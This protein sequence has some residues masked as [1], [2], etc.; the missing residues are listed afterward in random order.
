MACGSYGGWSAIVG[1]GGYG[2]AGAVPT[3]G[4]V[5]SRTYVTPQL[6]ALSDWLARVN[7]PGDNTH[8]LNTMSLGTNAYIGGNELD[9]GS[10][11]AP[12][13]PVTGGG[14]F[15]LQGGT[16]NFDIPG[17]TTGGGSL[18]AA[19]GVLNMQAGP[20][21]LQGGV[22]TNNATATPDGSSIILNGNMKYNT[23][24]VAPPSPLIIGSGGCFQT[25]PPTQGTLPNNIPANGPNYGPPFCQDALQVNGDA[26]VTGTLSAN[27]LYAGTFIYQSSDIRLK[28]N[29]KPIENPL[30]IS[31]A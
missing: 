21:Y 23:L 18:N 15:N 9:M 14:A 2:F 29:I 5:A 8:I 28:T 24:G 20:I 11:G 26:N 25:W 17:A 7:M 19:G 13:L 4:D 22:L 30:Q 6:N 12:T 31:C 16:I 1:A 27:G 10:Y 3:S